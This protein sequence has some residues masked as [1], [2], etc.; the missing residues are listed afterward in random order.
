MRRRR[1]NVF[2]CNV[3]AKHRAA[4]NAGK[5]LGENASAAAHIEGAHVAGLGSQRLTDKLHARGIE[6]VQHAYGRVLVVPPSVLE[7]GELGDLG[8]DNRCRVAR[9]RAYRAA[10]RASTRASAGN[11]ATGKA[12]HR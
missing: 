10:A 6:R 3:D 2:S 5:G 7:L 8:R 12:L 4:S 1:R 9:G 11:H